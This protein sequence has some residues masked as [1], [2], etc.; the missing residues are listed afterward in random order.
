MKFHDKA[1]KKHSTVLGAI[2]G[3][4]SKKADDFVRSKMPSYEE[5]INENEH[6]YDY[7]SDRRTVYPSKNGTVT[8]TN[9]TSEHQSHAEDKP[10]DIVTLATDVM[11]KYWN[12]AAV[13]TDVLRSDT[14]KQEL[15]ETELL[16]GEMSAISFR[17]GCYT[18]RSAQRVYSVHKSDD[19]IELEIPG[20]QTEVEYIKNLSPAFAG[21]PPLNGTLLRITNEISA[22]HNVAPNNVFTFVCRTIPQGGVNG[23][24]CI[25]GISTVKENGSIPDEY[26]SLLVYSHFEGG[27]FGVDTWYK[28]DPTGK[29]TSLKLHPHIPDEGNESFM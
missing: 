26:A 20:S 10:E 21:I 16:Q 14:E 25:G 15:V 9:A 1:G 12:S 13:F 28:L 11:K 18:V 17:V 22:K 3:N 4:I 24:E 29:I 2:M 6:L 8:G 27:S 5:T 7:V 19:S 23:C